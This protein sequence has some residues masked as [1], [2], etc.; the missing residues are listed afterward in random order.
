MLLVTAVVVVLPA[1]LTAPLASIMQIF[2]PLQHLFSA[3]LPGLADP[4]ADGDAL[5]DPRVEM[6]RN[7]IAAQTME[8]RRLRHENQAL[9]HLRQLG[10]QGGRLI[11]ARLV[12]ADSVAWRESRLIDQGTLRGI[13]RDAAVISSYFTS[14]GGADGVADGMSI[15]SGE[16]LIGEIVETRT[17]TARVLLLTDPE[18]RPRVV[19]IVHEGDS[20][21]EVLDAEFL[22]RGIGQGSMAIREVDHN[23]VQQGKVK[24]GDRVV[25]AAGDLNLPCEMVIGRVHEIRR[26]DDNAVLY[27]LTVKPLLDVSRLGRVYVIDQNPD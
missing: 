26:D 12:A 2:V 7:R 25:T 19:R 3:L 9:A 24:P 21:A 20:G 10:L 15:V 16:V 13:R 22:C 17:H 6:L 1:P 5:A 18:A 14:V 27:N 8:I 11:A 4:P 23:Y